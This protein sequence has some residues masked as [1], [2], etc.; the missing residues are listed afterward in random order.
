MRSVLGPCLRAAETNTLLH[1][2]AAP[3]HPFAR[4]QAP[5][6]NRGICSKDSCVVHQEHAYFHITFKKLL[7]A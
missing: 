2:Q 7:G 4:V 3:L 1:S 5:W 6:T